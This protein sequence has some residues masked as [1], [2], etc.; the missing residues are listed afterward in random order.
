MGFLLESPVQLADSQGPYLSTSKGALQI[1]AKYG[2]AN[3]GNGYRCTIH[4]PDPINDANLYQLLDYHPIG[5]G[6]FRTFSERYGIIGKVWRTGEPLLF[7]QVDNLPATA[8]TEAKLENIMSNWGMNRREAERALRRPSSI[9]LPLEHGSNKVGV[10]YVDSDIRD[11]F[12]NTPDAELETFRN[13][14]NAQLSSVLDEI[15][16]ELSSLKLGLDFRT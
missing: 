8:P 14:A 7:N 11:A 12:P 6:Q 5:T 4:I 16:D 1:L 2:R 10:L 3:V 9:C 15:I 13:A